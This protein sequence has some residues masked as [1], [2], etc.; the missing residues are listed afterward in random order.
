MPPLFKTLRTT[1]MTRDVTS[2]ILHQLLARIHKV[3]L[4]RLD[5]SLILSCIAD[6]VDGYIKDLDPTV[7]RERLG[8]EPQRRSWKVCAVSSIGFAA[9]RRN[10]VPSFCTVNHVTSLDASVARSTGI[11]ILIYFHGSFFAIK[12]WILA[13]KQWQRR[14][15][16]E[17]EAC[18]RFQ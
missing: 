6:T 4:G 9:S 8:W 12:A 14:C 17:L 16:E 3:Q 13:L 10:L 5:M 18:G 15:E 7:A 11:R 2:T 1:A